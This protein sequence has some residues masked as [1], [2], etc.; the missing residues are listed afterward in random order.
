[1]P[2]VPHSTRPRRFFHGCLTGSLLL[3][4]VSSLAPTSR[5][6]GTQT[7]QRVFEV[8]MGAPVESSVPAKA[9]FYQYQNPPESEPLSRLVSF[10]DGMLTDNDDFA[11]AIWPGKK[12]GPGAMTIVFDVQEDVDIH[13]VKLHSRIP[14][15]H[16]GIESISV[17]TRGSE[18]AQYRVFARVEKPATG[19]TDIAI[20]A[21]RA[22]GRYV[23]IKLRKAH[24]YVYTGLAEVRI[25]TARSLLPL[26]PAEDLAA[27]F[28]K[29]TRGAGP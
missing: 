26:Q 20:P 13:A 1:M 3:L 11:L 6:Q 23:R 9:G 29:G 14:N 2:S 22:T 27:E 12:N 28:T 21:R 8:S 24:E 16:W 5:A 19:W 10:A 25:L 17:E 18:D 7:A 15:E 4:G